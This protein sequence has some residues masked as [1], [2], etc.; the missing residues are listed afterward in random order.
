[1]LVLR[2][3]EGGHGARKVVDSVEVS[4]E[5]GVHGDRW[6]VDEER[7]GEDQVSLINIHVIASL[8]PDAAR[9]H[10]TGDNLHVDLDLTEENL[11][12][13]TRLEIGSAVLEVSPQPHMPCK[14]FLTRFGVSAVKKVLRANKKRR[15][16]RGVVCL[17]RQAGEFRVGDEIRVLR[18]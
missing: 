7:T 16:G 10:L 17:V 8:E 12:V 11:P 3:P 4:P 5:L 13:G 1:M 2:P 6:A 15:R 14:H 18:G 9:R